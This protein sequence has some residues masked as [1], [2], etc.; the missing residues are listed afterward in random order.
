MYVSMMATSIGHPK[1]LNMGI[2]NVEASAP[3][4]SFTKS[5][6]HVDAA[7]VALLRSAA[8]AIVGTCKS[9]VETKLEIGVPMSAKG[10]KCK[11]IFVQK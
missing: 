1:V 7:S 10:E 6:G 8:M 9:F 3:R 5:V 4:A 2:L 11:L